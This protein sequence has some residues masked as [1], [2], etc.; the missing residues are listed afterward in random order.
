[1]VPPSRTQ[2]P[3]VA[4]RARVVPVLVSV[5]VRLTVPPLRLKVPSWASANVPP[6]FTVELVAVMVPPLDQLPERFSVE[7]VTVVVLLLDQGPERLRLPPFA[8]SSGPVLDQVA[9]LTVTAPPLASASM[10]P[11]L[12]R[13]TLLGPPMLPL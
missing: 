9:A 11:W 1:M 2:V 8:A 7:F 5:P 12:T 4:L 10:V 3:V 13:L 6:R